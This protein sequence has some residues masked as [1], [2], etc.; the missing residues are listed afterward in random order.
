MGVLYTIW[1]L[2]ETIKPWL[3]ELNVFYGDALSRFPTG[4]E[5]KQV[6]HSM[7]D[8]ES[9]ITDNGIGGMWQAYLVHKDNGGER[10]LY[11]MLNVTNYSGDDEPQELWFAKGSEELNKVILKHLTVFCGPLVFIPATGD[12]PTVVTPD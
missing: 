8:Y 1:P 7:Q 3:D 5:I 10:G 9:E 11:A 12:T 2:D 4:S 6:V